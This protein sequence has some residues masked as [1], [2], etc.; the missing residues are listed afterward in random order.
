MVINLRP[1][2]SD[3]WNI[4]TDLVLPLGVDTFRQWHEDKRV[5]QGLGEESEGAKASP[6]EA[7]AFRE[8]PQVVAG[9]SKA[10]LPT[11]TTHQGERA[12]ETACKTLE[13]IRAIHLQTM[14]EMGSVRELNPSLHTHV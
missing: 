3:H 7:P 11:E 12:L 8:S 9:S 14:H 5:V 10:A 6:K 13:H 4:A 1:L 2:S